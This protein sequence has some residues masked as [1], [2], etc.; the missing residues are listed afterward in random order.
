MKKIILILFI[1]I[2]VMLFFYG[3]LV[4]HNQF[5]PFTLMKDLKLVVFNDKKYSSEE[6]LIQEN[7]DYDKLININN[8]DEV[9]QERL[10]IYD[11]LWNSKELPLTLPSSV[12][13]NFQDERY[14]KIEN[15]SDIDKIIVNMD[16][17]IN[18]VVYHFHAKNP[19]NKLIIYHQG[20]RGDFYQ[21]VET[22]EFF[23]E[24]N[25]DVL[26][27]SMPLLGMNDQ[28]IVETNFGK[29]QL[30]SHYSFNT[31]DSSKKSP[32]RFFIEPI[33]VVLNYIDKDFQYSSYSF[34]GLSGGGWTAIV[35]SAIDP[36]I[37]NTFSIAG[38]YPIF[39]RQEQK[40]YGDYEQILPE[41]YS[42][43]NYLDLYIM[44]SFGENRKLIQIFNEFDP[45]CFSGDF[46]RL[47]ENSIKLK[48]S[49]LGFGSF[50]TMIDDSHKE[51]KIS[52]K[53]L[54]VI[55]NELE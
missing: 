10:L 8:K 25:Y 42:I 19:N 13:K 11:F 1:G 6:F 26:A 36:R 24:K 54:K 27:F 16:Y 47:Y 35:Y 52:Q 33:S 29:I 9:K 50:Q 44:G 23:L 37:E 30:S 22:I 2:C 49:E 31:L 18:S 17:E 51:H 15:L 28:P 14:S 38:S 39:I 45:C 32:L 48:I 21:G 5:F 4:G 12:E 40:N 3:V 46:S 34:V 53:I 41:F 20:H 55:I 7:Q 43:A